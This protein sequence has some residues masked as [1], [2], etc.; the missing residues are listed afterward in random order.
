MS[1]RSDFIAVTMKL[2]IVT[3]IKIDNHGC[4]KQTQRNRTVSCKKLEMFARYNKA[5]RG[6]ERKKFYL[7]GN[8]FHFSPLGVETLEAV[9][10]K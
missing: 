6:E 9:A 10:H 4:Q 2:I 5:A 7:C 3:A 8:L 1:V